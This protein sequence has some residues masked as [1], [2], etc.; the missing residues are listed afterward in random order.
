VQFA[1]LV[2]R[3]GRE[4]PLHADYAGIIV[5]AGEL[6]LEQRVS[7]RF[8]EGDGWDEVFIRQLPSTSS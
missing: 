8:K 1:V 7:V 4:L 6:T 3:H 5:T 2:D